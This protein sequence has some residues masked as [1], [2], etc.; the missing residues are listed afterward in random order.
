[1]TVSSKALPLR[2]SA[3]TV[4]ASASPGV[5]GRSRDMIL[6]ACVRVLRAARRRAS[7]AGVKRTTGHG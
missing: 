7:R 2:I 5:C 6:R 1:M 4:R 3:A